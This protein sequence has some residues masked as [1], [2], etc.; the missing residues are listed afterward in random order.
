VQPEAGG[1]DITNDYSWLLQAGGYNAVELLHESQSPKSFSWYPE[2]MSVHVAPLQMGHVTYAELQE[3]GRV[4]K[5]G[6][7]PRTYV[8]ELAH[9]IA[10][11]LLQ[12]TALED[13]DVKA[14]A[15]RFFPFIATEPRSMLRS[16]RRTC[17]R[18]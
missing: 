17:C 3:L 1:I 11:K 2:S 6:H 14:A 5:K 16:S 18:L 9:H 4:S 12:G 10:D 7:A 13:I 15:T 8:W